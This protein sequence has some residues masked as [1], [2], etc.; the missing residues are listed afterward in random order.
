[1]LFNVLISVLNVIYLFFMECFFKFELESFP[2]VLQFQ[3][4]VLQMGEMNN[5]HFISQNM[6]FGRLLCTCC[7]LAVGYLMPR[8][9]GSL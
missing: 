4:S 1:M 8:K 3:V 5:L 9:P 7:T 6:A 2:F